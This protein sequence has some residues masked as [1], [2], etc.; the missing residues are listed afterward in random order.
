M[1]YEVRLDKAT[2]QQTR[3]FIGQF[4]DSHPTAIEKHGRIPGG[5]YRI[6]QGL[7]NRAESDWQREKVYFEELYGSINCFD[8]RLLIPLSRLTATVELGCRCSNIVTYG[9]SYTQA[10]VA[11]WQEK[12]NTQA[13]R[14]FNL[15]KQIA[16]GLQKKDLK[17]GTLASE[18]ELLLVRKYRLRHACHLADL[19][20]TL[21]QHYFLKS[22]SRSQSVL[23][24]HAQC[25]R[26]LAALLI[27]ISRADE[28][29]TVSDM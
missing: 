1:H 21:R 9:K 13:L 18:A 14:M 20:M 29:L 8:N 15:I 3:D 24:L 4:F 16:Q 12:F 6:F 2:L 25:Q 23:E 22:R 19:A 10:P 27:D 28:A 11:D 26:N 5:T 17:N 7:I